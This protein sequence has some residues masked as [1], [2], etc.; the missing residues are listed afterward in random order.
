VSVSFNNES[1]QAERK[2]RPRVGPVWEATEVLPDK[3][4]PLNAGRYKLEKSP[5]RGL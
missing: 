5:C 1:L 2:G 3:N 4:Y